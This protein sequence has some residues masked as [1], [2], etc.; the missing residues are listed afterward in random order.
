M[1]RCDSA[2]DLVEYSKGELEP[3][4][5][6]L[7]ATHLRE[8]PACRRELA[9]IDAVFS[10]LRRDLVPIELSAHFRLALARRIDSPADSAGPGRERPSVRI[11][12]ECDPGTATRLVAH[13][14]R[15]PYFV[16]SLF[17]HAA[18]VL[19]V[20]GLVFMFG[21]KEP[22]AAPTLH[23]R[24]ATPDAE[25]AGSARR[26]A[27]AVR[28]RRSAT[29]TESRARPVEGGVEVDL[30]SLLTPPTGRLMLYG[31]AELGCVRALPLSAEEPLLAAQLREAHPDAVEA[32]VDGT[33]LRIPD[34]L[35]RSHL[36]TADL[37]VFALADTIEFWSRPTW[38]SLDERC[39]REGLSR[40]PG[41]RAYPLFAFRRRGRSGAI[42]G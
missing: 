30:A 25:D 35:A 15:S 1:S 14:K 29:R 26:L 8:C 22:P 3:A 28:L 18:A 6:E 38:N 33:L 31:D 21:R 42:E 11:L 41:D 40:E 5:A 9:S 4:A 39:R 20:A 19:L 24:L 16:L 37:F 17:A 36:P 32:A 10:A 2:P 13:A 23:F 7:V 27:S 12:R 34:T